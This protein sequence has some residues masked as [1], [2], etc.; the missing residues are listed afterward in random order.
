MCAWEFLT[1]VP[2]NTAKLAGKSSANFCNVL[3]IDSTKLGFNNKSLGGY[4]QI[5]NSGVNNKRTFYDAA[6]CDISRIF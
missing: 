6:C 5:D 2:T 4:P 1:T 3:S